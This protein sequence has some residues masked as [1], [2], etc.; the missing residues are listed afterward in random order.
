MALLEHAS[1]EA[2][3]C[4]TL[5][6]ASGALR[7]AT[8]LLDR[9]EPLLQRLHQL[10]PEGLQSQLA[11]PPRRQSLPAA[12]STALGRQAAPSAQV[13]TTTQMAHRNP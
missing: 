6:P 8:L 11:S 5:D 13:T 3:A 4:E 2:Q 1:E 12:L 9:L 7:R 10:A